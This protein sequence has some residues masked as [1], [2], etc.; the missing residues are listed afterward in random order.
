[1]LGVL[2]GKW[3]VQSSWLEACLQK[4]TIVEEEAHESSAGSVGEQSGPILGRMSQGLK[5]LK[6]WEVSIETTRAVSFDAS[7]GSH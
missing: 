4:E 1:M 2:G 6:H 7:I 5:L 3:V